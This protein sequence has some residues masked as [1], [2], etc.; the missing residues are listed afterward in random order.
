MGRE[1]VGIVAEAYIQCWKGD[2]P[3]IL[4]GE[5]E[6]H[7]EHVIADGKGLGLNENES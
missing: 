6:A 5:Q 7:V 2:G 1:A 3:V 4:V